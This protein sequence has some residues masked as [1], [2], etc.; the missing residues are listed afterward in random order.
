MKKIKTVKDLQDFTEKASVARVESTI[1]EQDFKGLHLV[2]LKS[3][4]AFSKDIYRLPQISNIIRDSDVVL[5]TGHHAAGKRR[6][7]SALVGPQ[8]LPIHRPAFVYDVRA[9]R[10]MMRASGELED[11]Q[12]AIGMRL[13]DDAMLGYGSLCRLAD[14]AV[15]VVDAALAAGRRQAIMARL[16]VMPEKSFS[17]CVLLLAD[18]KKMTER[19]E[20]S[21]SFQSYRRTFDEYLMETS[22]A[23]P[24][25]LEGFRNIVIINETSTKSSNYISNSS[26]KE[27]YFNIYQKNI[28]Y[29]DYSL[30]SI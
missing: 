11:K 5:V 7:T 1:Y 22:I 20:E 15:V 14:M 24:R 28:K 6:F 19:N 8:P 4:E 23:F 26:I 21:R 9:Q 13:V 30:G 27:K 25:F 2:S 29:F 3:I 10:D 18:A 17:T 12:H 16:G